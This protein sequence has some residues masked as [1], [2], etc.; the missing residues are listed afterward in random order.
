MNENY[1]RSYQPRQPPQPEPEPIPVPQP[2]VKKSG[3]KIATA[4]VIIGLIIMSVFL[5]IQNNTYEKKITELELQ[6]NTTLAFNQGVV[7]SIIQLMK[8]TDNCQVASIK[9]INTTRQ[10]VNIDCVRQ[11]LQQQNITLK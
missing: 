8:S 6:G 10:I 4:I 1:G 7:A 3:W 5:F 9:Y 2:E 11:L